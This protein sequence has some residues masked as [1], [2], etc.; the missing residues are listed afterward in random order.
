MAFAFDIVI[1]GSQELLDGLKKLGD[2][3]IN[4]EKQWEQTGEYLQDFE[5]K[6]FQ[7]EGQIF[8]QKWQSL[9]ETTFDQKQKKYPGVGILTRTGALRGGFI[10]TV[11]GTSAL[12]HNT[13]DDQYLQYHQKGTSKMPRRVIYKLDDERKSGIRDIFVNGIKEQ[14]KEAFPNG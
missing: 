7:S 5:E 14:L 6:V 13:Y 2:G 9:K 11:M 12:F 10:F 4:L 3:V 8:N 1:S